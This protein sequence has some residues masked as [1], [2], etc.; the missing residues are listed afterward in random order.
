MSANLSLHLILWQTAWTLDAQI[1]TGYAIKFVLGSAIC[2]IAKTSAS[3]GVHG[4]NPLQR[5]LWWPLEG[6]PPAGSV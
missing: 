1:C 5:Q 2:I 4:F 6:D 3:T